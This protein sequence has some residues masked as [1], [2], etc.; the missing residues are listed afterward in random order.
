MKRI[1]ETLKC[2][3]CGEF[4]RYQ[5]IVDG[6]AYYDMIYPSSHFT[7]ETYRGACRKC[8]EKNDKLSNI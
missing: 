3:Y 7:E 6:L 4:I 2:S 5:D 8:K 1:H